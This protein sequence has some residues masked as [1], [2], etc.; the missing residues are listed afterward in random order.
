MKQRNLELRKLNLWQEKTI[1]EKQ[2]NKIE[3]FAIDT[4]GLTL[5]KY[6]LL[7]A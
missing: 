4:T 5:F 1:S 6:N 2:N 7:S 3:G